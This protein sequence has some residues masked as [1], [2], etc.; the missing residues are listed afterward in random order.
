MLRTGTDMSVGIV[1]DERRGDGGVLFTLRGEI[2]HGTVEPLTGV[3]TRVPADAGSVTLDMAGVTYMDSAGLAFLRAV[4]DFQRRTGIPVRTV[5]W[6]GRPRRVLEFTALDDDGAPAPGP[7]AAA[8]EREELARQL[9]EEVEQLR[10]A[11]VS[12]PLIDRATGVLMA[13]EVCTAEEA[14]GIL[15]ETSQRANV[16]LRLVARAVV[17]SVDG[18]PPEEPVLSALRFALLRHRRT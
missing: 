11:L 13:A 4:D 6:S 1:V 14:W 18:P 5:H 9:E 2:V 15:R 16:K 10:Q 3:L 12:R 17:R 8:R 7:S